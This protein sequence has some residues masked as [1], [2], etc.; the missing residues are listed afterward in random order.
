MGGIAFPHYFVRIFKDHVAL[1]VVN[2]VVYL[3]I[4]LIKKWTEIEL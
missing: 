2:Y 3:I 1:L 4:I